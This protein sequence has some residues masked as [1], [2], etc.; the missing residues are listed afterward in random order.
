M[1]TFLVLAVLAGLIAVA[2]GESCGPS[3]CVHTQ[4]D[5]TSQ[6]HCVDGLCTCTVQGSSTCSAKDDCPHCDNNRHRHCID[7]TCHCERF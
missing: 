5:A 2:F 7:G 4:C 1:R 6:L 3:Q